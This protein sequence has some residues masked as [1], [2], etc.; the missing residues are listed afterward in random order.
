MLM[1]SLSRAGDTSAWGMGGN[2]ER[3]QAV[4]KQN[5]LREGALDSAPYHAAAAYTE[6]GFAYR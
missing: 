4:R 2:I 3:Q 6:P 1:L 5:I